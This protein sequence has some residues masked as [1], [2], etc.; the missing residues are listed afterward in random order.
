MKKLIAKTQIGVE[1]FH[2]KTSAFFVSANAEKIIK[3]LNDAKYNLKEG[4]CWH[5]YDYDFSQDY[6]V[7][8][9]IYMTK[10]GSVKTISL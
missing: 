10:S 6:Y 8:K 5:L 2:S 1:F 3:A 7:E 9:R 4:E